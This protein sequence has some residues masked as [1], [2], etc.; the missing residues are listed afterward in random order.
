MEALLK[1]ILLKFSSSGFQ[2]APL[3]VFF[4][5]LSLLTLF[6]D[7][8]LPDWNVSDLQGSIFSPIIFLF[9]RLPLGYI[10]QGITSH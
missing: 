8:S 6:M 2:G 7:S 10:S 1:N 3:L 9:C 4:Q 5:F